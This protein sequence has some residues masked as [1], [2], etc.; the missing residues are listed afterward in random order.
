M[1][2][3]HAGDVLSTWDGMPFSIVVP[4]AVLDLSV[5]RD[6]P[7]WQRRLDAPQSGLVCLSAWI[8]ATSVF[9]GM[10]ALFGGPTQNDTSESLYATWSIAHGSFACS[11][12]PVSPHA[13]SFLLYFQPHPQVPVLWPL[14]SGGIAWLT[15]IG[16]TAPF[17]SQHTL[18]VNCVNANDIMYH[19]ARSSYAVFATVGLGYLSWFVLL[20]GVIALLRA[21]GRGRSGWEVFGVVFI[22]VVPIVWA[23]VLDEYHPQDMVAVGLVLASIAC[24][25]RREWVWAGMLLGLAVTT[26][27]FAL[28]ALA[29]LVVVVPGKARWRLLGAAAV[30]AVV[31]SLPMVIVTSGRAIHGVLLGTGDSMTLGG[32]VLWELSRGPVLVFSRGSC[33]SF[34]PL[35]SRGGRSGVWARG[36]S[37][38][39]H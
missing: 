22:A 23:P 15:R 13:A 39:S 30:A 32:T 5:E 18:G 6:T 9:F 21:S 35:Q 14:I 7:S 10:V 3:G 29:P 16:H 33:R 28:L 4:V 12:A 8:L 36:C 37:N 25:K 26:Q 34:S 1:P 11:Y 31:I 2:E 20:A 17:P 19:W 27:Q 24:V 38:R